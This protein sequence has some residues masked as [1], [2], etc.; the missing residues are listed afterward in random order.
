MVDLVASYKWQIITE[1][2]AVKKEC[3]ITDLV[4]QWLQIL[5]AKDVEVS[6]EEVG[7]HGNVIMWIGLATEVFV[8]WRGL[9]S[10]LFQAA[11]DGGPPA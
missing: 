7:W 5:I 9:F 11:R 6:I 3:S 1:G 10:G 4:D 2:A 8:F